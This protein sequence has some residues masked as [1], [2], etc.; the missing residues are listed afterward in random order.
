METVGGD[1]AA[2]D[3]AR[4]VAGRVADQPRRSG[5]AARRRPTRGLAPA[6]H[7]ELGRNLAARGVSDRRG[8]RG[9]RGGGAPLRPGGAALQRTSDDLQ[10]HNRHFWRS[11][12]ASW[13]PAAAPTRRASRSQPNIAGSCRTGSTRSS[14]RFEFGTGACADIQNDSL[15]AVEDRSTS[16]PEDVDADVRQGA[17]GGLRPPLRAHRA[18]SASRR[19]RRPRRSPRLRRSRSDGHDRDHPATH[20]DHS[21]AHR[22]RGTAAGG[23]R[24]GAGARGGRRRP[25]RRGRSDDSGQGGDA[26]GVQGGTGG[27]ALVP[28]DEG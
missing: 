24:D 11:P 19:R 15:P 5:P 26:S 27:G 4:S 23:H 22:D 16:M 2:A 3:G 6:R 25:R 12:A 7:R 9:D 28:G 20:R 1:Q 8:R 13:R 14:G 18:S 17:D 10:A 21:A